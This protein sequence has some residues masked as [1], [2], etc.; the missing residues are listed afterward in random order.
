VQ[1][2]GIKM[3]FKKMFKTM[4]IISIVVLTLL[5]VTITP[6]LGMTPMYRE[7][8]DVTLKPGAITPIDPIDPVVVVDTTA[9]ITRIKELDDWQNQDVFV[10]MRS[11][12]ASGVAKT[13]YDIWMPSV[14]NTCPIT[15]Y[16]EG[17]EFTV[18]AE[19]EWKMAYFS[20]DNVGNVEERKVAMV[21]ID[22]T[23]PITKFRKPEATNTAKF[24]VEFDGLDTLSGIKTFVYSLDG[25]KS[26][27]SADRISIETEGTYT[28]QVYAVDNAGNEGNVVEFTTTLDLPSNEDDDG[29]NSGSSS[30]GS[31]TYIAPQIINLT[32]AQVKAGYNVVLRERD[33]LKFKLEGKDYVFKIEDIFNYKVKAS[34]QG[35]SE[36]AQRESKTF[37]LDNDGMIDFKVTIGSVT[38]TTALVSVIAKEEIAPQTEAED[39]VEEAEDEVEE[40]FATEQAQEPS[41]MNKITGMVAGASAPV[42]VGVGVFVLLVSLIAVLLFSR[43]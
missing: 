12:D 40:Q 42:K 2:R 16:T 8:V 15:E 10:Q 4:A 25:G 35:V 27:V 23:A 32:E 36:F 41:F 14:E 3:N 29:G 19:G 22:K 31:S 28:V 21:K 9:P 18:S 20:V 43:K 26:L 38:S 5:M 30:S 6:A 34:L 13:L 17:T 11:Y 24:T 33:Q 37:D 7:K 1:K 39:E